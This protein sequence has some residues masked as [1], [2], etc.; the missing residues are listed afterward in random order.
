LEGDEEEA[1]GEAGVE[2]LASPL[3]VDE[4]FCASL[5][6]G[7]FSEVVFSEVVG[8]FILLE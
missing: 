4:S 3:G 8:S 2:G 1:V 7:D 5:G 6:E